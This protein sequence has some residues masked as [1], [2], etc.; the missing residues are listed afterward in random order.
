M[1]NIVNLISS[2]IPIISHTELYSISFFTYWRLQP[3]ASKSR[4]KERAVSKRSN[5]DEQSIVIFG[6]LAKY[7]AD[8]K[9]PN[10]ISILIFLRSFFFS[11]S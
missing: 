1:S 5:F 11:T 3:A 10:H 9:N 4:I 7:S 6:P 8:V 2:V